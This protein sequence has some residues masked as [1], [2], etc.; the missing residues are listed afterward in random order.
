MSADKMNRP[1]NQLKIGGFVI[2]IVLV[3]VYGFVIQENDSRLDCSCSPTDSNGS[4]IYKIL[5]V[6]IRPGPRFLIP[7]CLRFGS[8]TV[9]VRTVLDFTDFPGP[10]PV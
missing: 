2:M 7:V 4:E 6:L 10:D 3:M 9:L 5:S 1:N 8:G